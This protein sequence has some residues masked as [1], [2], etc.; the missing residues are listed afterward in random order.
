MRVLRTRGPTRIDI[1]IM[2]K[3]LNVVDNPLF[4]VSRISSEQAN[5]RDRFVDG[6]FMTGPD[7]S[8]DVTQQEAAYA[9]GLDVG[10]RAVLFAIPSGHFARRAIRNAITN[11]DVAQAED[12]TAQDAE[13]APVCE[14]QEITA[15]GT[16]N[17]RVALPH[18]RFT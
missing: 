8:D 6:R 11:Q 13:T 14:R 18:G 2:E 16:H 5:P 3:L 17:R 15:L 7:S 9:I 12:V 10:N 4:E 1:G